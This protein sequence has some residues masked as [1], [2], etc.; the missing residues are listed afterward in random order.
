MTAAVESA[1]YRDNRPEAY[2]VRPRGQ[3]RP[4]GRPLHML[5]GDTAVNYE[6]GLPVRS[7]GYVDRPGGMDVVPLNRTGRQALVGNAVHGLGAEFVLSDPAGDDPLFTQERRE[8]GEVCRGA[9][10][11]GT[12]RQQVPEQFPQADDDVAVLYFNSTSIVPS[13][14]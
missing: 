5:P 4:F 13:V 1:S 2:G 7:D 3:R 10:E 8:V 9:A 6:I 12:R 11:L 14:V